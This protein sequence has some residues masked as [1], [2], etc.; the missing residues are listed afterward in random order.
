MNFGECDELRS[1]FS[2]AVFR[3]ITGC[4]IININP[5]MLHANV[6]P[7][8]PG[9]QQGKIAPVICHMLFPP[10][11]SSIIAVK[12][13]SAIR[14]F[15]RSTPALAIISSACSLLIPLLAR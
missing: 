3:N 7:K 2:P 1:S 8:S 5:V 13:S 10:S 4:C 11:S 15:K 9:S 12:A 6:L 14:L